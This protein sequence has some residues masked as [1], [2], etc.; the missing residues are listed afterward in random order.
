MPIAPD[1]TQY[2]FVSAVPIV[3]PAIA[4]LRTLWYNVAARW[5]VRHLTLQQQERNRHYQRRIEEQATMNAHAVRS[6]LALSEEVSR[7][8]A[9]VEAER[10]RRG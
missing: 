1:L 3:G 4:R 6:L 2:E 5:A 7:L 10:E 8:I 9:Q